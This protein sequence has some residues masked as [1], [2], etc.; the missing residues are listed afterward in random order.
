MRQVVK[1]QIGFKGWEDLQIP[2]K[3]IS[4]KIDSC[5]GT[6]DSSNLSAEVQF[7]WKGQH[8][9]PL[10]MD[11][12]LSWFCSLHCATFPAGANA[13]TETEEAFCSPLHITCH[14][15]RIPFIWEFLYTSKKWGFRWPVMLKKLTNSPRVRS[16]LSGG[17]E[18]LWA[19]GVGATIGHGNEALVLEHHS[20][21]LSKHAE[22]RG[23]LKGLEDNN[24]AIMEHLKYHERMGMMDCSN[25]SYVMLI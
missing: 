25:V 14:A 3:L 8:V 9:V 5:I 12:I 2:I 6:I 19:V 21:I 4:Y 13:S 16:H 22:H 24:S 7:Y 1:A 15:L 17:D 18:E 11:L 23:C 20:K 10:L